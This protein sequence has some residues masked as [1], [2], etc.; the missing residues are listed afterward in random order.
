MPYGT[1]AAFVD[2]ND[3]G[4]LLKM[5]MDVEHAPTFRFVKKGKVYKFDTK[6]G[7][8]MA[9]FAVTQANFTD[10]INT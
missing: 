9:E 3:E 8:L 10:L 4:E 5:T 7:D 6:P 1:Q 2:I